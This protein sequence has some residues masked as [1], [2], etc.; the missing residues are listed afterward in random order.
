MAGTRAVLQAGLLQQFQLTVFFVAAEKIRRS[1]LSK[2]YDRTMAAHMVGVKVIDGVYVQLNI[3]ALGKQEINYGPSIL[4]T[5]KK[6][7]Q[8]L[9]EE[10]SAEAVARQESG[11]ESDAVILALNATE[12]L[13]VGIEWVPIRMG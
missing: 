1:G 13:P 10:S 2:R 9:D 4:V 3:L 6:A 11:Y 8:G 7:S 5:V 12:D